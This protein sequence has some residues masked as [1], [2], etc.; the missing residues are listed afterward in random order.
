GRSVDLN[1]LI[2]D[3]W[4]F[5]STFVS[6]AA[7]SSTPHIYISML[8]FWPELSP[9][10]KCYRRCTQGMIG[11]EG[12]AIG[13]KQHA[14]I[15]TWSFDHYERAIWSPVFSPDGTQIAAGL[16]RTIL[17]LDSSIGRMA[18]PPFGA[19]AYSGPVRSVQFS[20]SGSRIVGFSAGIMCV[21]ST[22]SGKPI[23]GSFEEQPRSHS[24]RPIIG[25]A[26]SPDGA[27]LASL[28]KTYGPAGVRART[29]ISIWSAFSGERIIGPLRFD[30]GPL[31]TEQ[32]KYSPDGH[33]VV[34]SSVEGIIIYEV[35]GGQVPRVLGTCNNSGSCTS[36]DISPDGAHIASGYDDNSIRIWDWKTGQLALGPI[37][38][39]TSITGTQVDSISF[40]PDGLHFA[41]GSSDD[42]ICM[43]NTQS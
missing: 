32:I 17:L 13:Q 14:L 28:S 20:P 1:A 18:L 30:Y 26:F 11:I 9:V 39:K 7:Y 41:S 2:H 12:T 36:F 40:S 23:L 27:Y 24:M 31:T 37:D 19:R 4:R 8:P 10:S 25:A 6:S 29:Q 21:W 34:F 3:A 16:G 15:A 35:R 42:T 22:Q 33:S 5:T 38:I 43:W